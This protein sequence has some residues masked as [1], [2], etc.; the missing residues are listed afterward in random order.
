MTHKEA[1]A[2][3]ARIAKLGETMGTLEI[4]EKLGVSRA[5]VYQTLAR[6]G[7]P[8]KKPNGRAF[9]ILRRLLDGDRGIDI[10]SEYGISRQ[11]VNQVKV[12]A[13]KAGFTFNN[14]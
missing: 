14:S 2:R 6:E 13:E 1:R 12:E 10:A 8:S 9:C 7:I 11:R 5:Y 4:A 3:R